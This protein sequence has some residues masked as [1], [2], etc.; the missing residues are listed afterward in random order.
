MLTR[1]GLPARTCLDNLIFVH[2][3]SGDGRATQ[4]DSSHPGY[5]ERIRLLAGFSS[6]RQRSASSSMTSDPPTAP[7]GTPGTFRY[8]SRKNLLVFTPQRQ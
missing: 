7:G 5:D 2:H 4:N 8:D 6:K 1:A 3:S